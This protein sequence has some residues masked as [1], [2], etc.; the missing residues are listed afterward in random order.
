MS[1]AIGVHPG[2]SMYGLQKAGPIEDYVLA[3]LYA[4]LEAHSGLSHSFATTAASTLG[5]NTTS[6]SIKR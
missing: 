3:D 1:P 4:W 6:S 2:S 5:A